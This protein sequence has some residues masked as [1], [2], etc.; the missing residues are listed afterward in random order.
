[1][2]LQTNKEHHGSLMF[3]AR[4]GPS[5]TSK[6][7][8]VDMLVCRQPCLG[9]IHKAKHVPEYEMELLFVWVSR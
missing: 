9:E 2:T 3:P 5:Y 6:W 8:C 7:R 4:P 1:V